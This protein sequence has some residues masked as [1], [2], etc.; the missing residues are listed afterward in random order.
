M[1]PLICPGDHG[2]FATPTLF[3]VGVQNQP[4]YLPY[5]AIKNGDYTGF[6]RELLDM[7]AEQE[8]YKFEYRPYPIKRLYL[9][10][11]NLQVDFKYPDNPYWSAAVK[12]DSHI[13]Y[14]TPVVD[15]IDGVM[16]RPEN[17]SMDAPAIEDLGILAGFTPQP[18][19]KQIEA[20]AMRSVE[21]FGYEKLLRQTITGTLDGAYSNIQVSKYYLEQ[22]LSKPGALVYNQNL[23]F[24]RS[25]RH[26][27]SIKHPHI[28]KKFDTFLIT[29][30]KDILELKQRYGLE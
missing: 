25:Q 21:I 20:G 26:L 27:S 19:I 17:I 15:Y 4:F 28:I 22:V 14:S 3:T 23:P 11:V 7:F 9:T 2:P 16:V 29:R 10:F 13:N 5:S 30:K 1:A 12:E 8:G 6:N 18:Y 24:I